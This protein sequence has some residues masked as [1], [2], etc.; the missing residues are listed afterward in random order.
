MLEE[1]PTLIV[2]CPVGWCTP[3]VV[4]ETNWWTVLSKFARPTN[5]SNSSLVT[6]EIKDTKDSDVIG[7]NPIYKNNKLVGRATSGGY[8][9]RIEKSLAMAMIDPFFVDVGNTFEIDIL[10]N[11]YE[12]EIIG[13]SPFDKENKLLRN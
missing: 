5:T 12:G 9:F 13:E 3:L 6:L 2:I 11:K 10:G 7:G 1:I 4:A 8:G